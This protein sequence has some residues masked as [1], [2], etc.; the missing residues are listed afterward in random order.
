MPC[1]QRDNS[2]TASLRATATTARFFSRALPV[3][4]KSL[5][6][7]AQRAGR[8]EGAQDI[9]RGA[10]QQSAQQTVAAFADAQ[11]FVRAA[12]LVAARTQTQ[13]R[14]HI[15]PAAE[16]LRVADLQDEAQRGERADAGDLLEALRG[17]IILFAALHQ[18]AFHPLDLFGHL[19][20]HGEQRL[21]HRQTIGGHV[22]QHGFVKR[23]AGG[24]A[25]GMAEAL[26]GEADGVD[27]VDAG[28]DEG[29]AQFEAEQIV[30]GLGGAVLDGMEQAPGP[31]G[32]AGRASGRRAGRTC[33][34][35]G[36]WRGACAGW[37]PA[38]WPRV[39]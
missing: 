5:A 9:M 19:G 3:P 20:E 22:G 10:D 14:P 28:A 15:A 11:L 23:L 25:H 17:G 27:E 32:P 16:P 30:L 21:H 13:I 2:S 6:V 18:V 39:R 31:R 4:V 29:I 7:F 8:A 34:R 38:P 37:R 26:E 36:R 33:V 12:A 24:I 35:S 1:F